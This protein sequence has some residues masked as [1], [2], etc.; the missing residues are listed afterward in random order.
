MSRK[1]E[2]PA[3]VFKSKRC[4]VSAKLR[5]QTTRE[6]RPGQS[7][8]SLRG[9]KRCSDPRSYATVTRTVSP[10]GASGKN[11]NPPMRPTTTYDETRGNA[12]KHPTAAKF[13]GVGQ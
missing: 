11:S 9:Y 10:T 2:R 1:S 7:N 13:G 6:R 5:N 3:S 8:L 4:L 12:A